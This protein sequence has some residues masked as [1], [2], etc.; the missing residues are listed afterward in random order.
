MVKTDKRPAWEV[1]GYEEA[2]FDRRP[3]ERFLYQFEQHKVALGDLAFA[4]R[5]KGFCVFTGG[6]GTGKTTVLRQA[7]DELDTSRITPCY[8][9]IRD[10]STNGYSIMQDMVEALGN[11]APQ[12]GGSQAVGRQLD[13]ILVELFETRVLPLL[14]IDEAQEL[15]R[16]A[17]RTIRLLSD[18]QLE[19]EGIISILLI[20]QPELRHRLLS[21]EWQNLAQRVT[22]WTELHGLARDE[23]DR[24]VRH[25]LAAAG[26]TPDLFSANAIDLIYSRTEGVPRLVNRL[27]EDCIVYFMDPDTHEPRDQQI[28]SNFVEAVADKHPHLQ[29][30]RT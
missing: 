22:V 25:R 13:R 14:I 16:R 12:W 10:E 15:R 21:A 11:E 23:V 7:L 1:L 17:L 4:L 8:I 18:Y 19:G 3:D 29:R 20:G 30:R 2:P 5:T 6:I 9:R 27:C 24:Y 26:G 28:K